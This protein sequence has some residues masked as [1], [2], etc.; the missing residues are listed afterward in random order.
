MALVQTRVF[1]IGIQDKE[2]RMK[3]ENDHKLRTRDCNTA[4]R[5]VLGSD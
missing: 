5:I 4:F 3:N 1:E 2:A